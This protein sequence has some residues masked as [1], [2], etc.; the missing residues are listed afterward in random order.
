MALKIA[1]ETL[2]GHI[3]RHRLWDFKNTF[4]K[5]KWYRYSFAQLNHPVKHILLTLNELNPH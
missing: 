4:K 5:W 3:S 2:Q 1:H